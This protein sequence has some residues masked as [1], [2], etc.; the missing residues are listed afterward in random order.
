MAGNEFVQRIEERRRPQRPEEARERTREPELGEQRHTPA[1]VAGNRRAVPAHQP[2]TLAAGFL[3][4]G[5]EQLL[6]VGIRQ[7]EEGQLLV[8]VKPGDNPRR[9]ATE[10]SAAGIEENRPPQA[11]DPAR[12]LS[13]H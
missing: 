10:L 3:G 12:R 5:R 7:R 11:A 13:Y 8:S 2:P 4:N 9:P 1:A 6:R